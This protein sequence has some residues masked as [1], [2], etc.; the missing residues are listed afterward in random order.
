[1][2]RIDGENEETVNGEMSR[3]TILQRTF[4]KPIIY[5]SI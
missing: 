4:Y 2:T 1:M 5:H 3:L